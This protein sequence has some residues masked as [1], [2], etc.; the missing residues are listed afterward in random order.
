MIRDH[1]EEAPVRILVGLPLTPLRIRLR[2]L[3]D[4]GERTPAWVLTKHSFFYA[5]RLR[6]ATLWALGV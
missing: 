1:V 3:Q 4:S 2:N 5:R 6:V